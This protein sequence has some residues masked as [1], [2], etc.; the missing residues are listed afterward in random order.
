[1]PVQRLRVL[2]EWDSTARAWVTLVPSLGS[3][4]TYGDTREEALDRT[5]DAILGY[6]E[7]ATREGLP[8]PQAGVEPELVELEVATP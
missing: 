1:M 8:L 7:A 4:S 2:L 6:I 5:R 3:L